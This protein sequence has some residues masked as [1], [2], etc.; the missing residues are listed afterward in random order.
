MKTHSSRPHWRTGFT[1]VE[2]LVVIALVAGLVALALI[3][4]RKA[5]AAAAKSRS[6]GQ[7]R[8]IAAAAA[9]WASE[10]N[11]GEPMYFANG[12]GDFGHEGKLPGKNPELSPGNPAKL[13]YVKDD[14]SSSYLSD[15]SVFFTPLCNFEKPSVKQYN[16]ASA[17]GT[18]PWGNFVWLYPSTSSLTPRQSSSMG[19]FSNKTIGR[20]AYD[21]VILGNDYQFA[22]SKPRYG[23][24]Y[25]ALFRDGSV[26]YI[27]DSPSMWTD[28]YTGKND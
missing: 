23:T 25:H 3:G 5:M 28:W 4:T 18:V 6:M 26:K 21:K 19:G 12:T 10:K 1:L 2:L 27:G 11:N 24:H 13:L 15:F 16:P 9:M 8:Q 14:P 7:M 20:E 22:F 17:S